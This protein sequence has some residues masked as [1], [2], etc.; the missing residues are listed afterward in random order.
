LLAPQWAFFACGSKEGLSFSFVLAA[1]PPKRMKYIVSSALP[2][3]VLSLSKGR[4]KA[5]A[6]AYVVSN[7]L[8]CY[9]VRKM[10]YMSRFSADPD[11]GAGFG[12]LRERHDSF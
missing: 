10:S 12:S 6:T 11:Y 2:P 5:V 1:S 7:D 9:S 3:P 4:K 8:N